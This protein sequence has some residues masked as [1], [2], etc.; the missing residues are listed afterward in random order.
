LEALGAALRAAERRG[1]V[2][3]QDFWAMPGDTDC[4]P[5]DRPNAPLPLRRAD[6]IAPAEYQAAIRVVL[7]LAVGCD[8]DGLITEMARLL[9]FDRTGTDL[10]V[11]IR[12]QIEE[13]CVRGE[14]EFVDGQIRERKVAYP[15]P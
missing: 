15:H 8:Q 13:L 12:Q 10:Q 4:V 5:R 9:G 14:T 7:K 3:D 11:A 2:R 6:R 1:V